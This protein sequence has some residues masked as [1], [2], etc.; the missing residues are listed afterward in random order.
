MFPTS[1]TSFD[2]R[3]PIRLRTPGL[4]SSVCWIPW[5]NFIT[6]WRSPGCMQRDCS[7]REG[8][9]RAAAECFR[10]NH[11]A[12]STSCPHKQREGEGEF[13]VYVKQKGLGKFSDRC[14]EWREGG[15]LR[16]WHGSLL[17]SGDKCEEGRQS[18]R[19][20]SLAALCDVC[21]DSGERKKD[22][23][24]VKSKHIIASRHRLSPLLSPFFPS[25]GS[26]SPVSHRQNLS[27]TKDHD[28]F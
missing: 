23:D 11:L 6:K 13:S 8:E 7:C 15:R 21:R 24:G 28:S 9:R 10:E 17:G 19:C 25:R 12:E 27:E 1:S 14:E 2:Q 20:A 22:G 3:S 26:L 18:K 5:R 16:E 4:G